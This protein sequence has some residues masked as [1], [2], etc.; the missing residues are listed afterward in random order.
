MVQLAALIA[1][2]AVTEYR[3]TLGMSPTTCSPVA[4]ST[5]PP[6]FIHR[7]D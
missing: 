7:K 3:S 5:V 4:A 1:C 6:L 2:S